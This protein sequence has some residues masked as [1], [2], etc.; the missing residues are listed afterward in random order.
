[1][2]PTR[3]RF[4]TLRLPMSGTSPEAAAAFTVR[5]TALGAVAAFLLRP[6]TLHPSLADM[7]MEVMEA[8]VLTFHLTVCVVMTFPRVLRARLEAIRDKP[9][10]SQNS[11]GLYPVLQPSANQISPLLVFRYGENWRFAT[12]KIKKL[13]PIPADEKVRIGVP[14]RGKKRA[15]RC[16]R[17]IC[18]TAPTEF[19]IARAQATR[20]HA[21]RS[22]PFQNAPKHS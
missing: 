17:R 2:A 13:A 18:S 6:R 5:A 8:M 11:A 15:K 21:D 4:I 19:R 7:V 14:G 9:E 1:M 20:T 22:P 16:L 10:S 3:R 12:G